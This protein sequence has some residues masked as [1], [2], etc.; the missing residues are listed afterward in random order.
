MLEFAVPDRNRI[1]D[2]VAAISR[3]GESEPHADKETGV[4][5]VGVG[6][7]GSDTLVDAVRSLDSA[8]VQTKGLALRQ[9]GRAHV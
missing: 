8:G 9:I 1:S 4:V 5:S 7:R 3:I 6:G 2:A